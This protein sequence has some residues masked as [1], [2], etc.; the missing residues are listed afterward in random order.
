MVENQNVHNFIGGKEI[1]IIGDKQI[2]GLRL[3][4][5]ELRILLLSISIYL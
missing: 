2:L 4:N 5:Q 3:A 1:I